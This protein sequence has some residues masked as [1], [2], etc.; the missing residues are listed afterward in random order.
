MASWEGE[1]L[2][3]E[4]NYQV[5]LSILGSLLAAALESSLK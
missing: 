3:S 1:W 4:G 2:V 5:S